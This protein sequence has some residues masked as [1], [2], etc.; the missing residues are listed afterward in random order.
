MS[1]SNSGIRGFSG[2]TSYLS[3]L[4]RAIRNIGRELTHVHPVFRKPIERLWDG[5]ILA[6]VYGVSRM[7]ARRYATHTSLDPFAVV[8]V[9]PTRITQTVEQNGYPEQARSENIFPTPK[10][11]YAGTVRDGDWD[12]GGMCFEDTELYRSFEAHFER[13]VDWEET[14]FFQTVVNLIESGTVMWGCTSKAEFERR[15]VRIDELYETI[16]TDGYQS[17]AELSAQ[18]VEDPGDRDASRI[19][20]L[21]NHELTV[22][23]GRDGEL[24][25]VDGRNRLAIAKL[26]DL[27]SIPVWIPVRHAQWQQFREQLAVDPS[28]CADIPPRLQTHPDL[29]DICPGEIDQTPT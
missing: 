29:T 9:N 5:Y 14:L 7:H 11:K 3:T 27:D 8:R 1:D 25:F 6:Y 23:I 24:L 16:G 2:I 15:C 22:A 18:G 13:G 12:R 21:V 17:Q 26:L 19:V 28:R 20:R 10:F 4:E